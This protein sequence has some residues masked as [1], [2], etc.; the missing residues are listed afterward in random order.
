MRKNLAIV[1]LSILLVLVS[2]FSMLAVNGTLDDK[3]RLDEENAQYKKYFSEIEAWK[4]CVLG[5]KLVNSN[6]E[7]FIKLADVQSCGKK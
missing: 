7:Q 1:V 2:V 5:A 3:H 6:S 4:E